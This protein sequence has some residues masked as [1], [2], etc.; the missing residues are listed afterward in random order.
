MSAVTQGHD[1]GRCSH[2]IILLGLLA[3]AQ[4]SKGVDNDTCS[5]AVHATTR[6]YDMPHHS[7]TALHTKDDVQEHSEQDN[8]EE[9]VVDEAKG[10]VAA[11]VILAS[12]KQ[13]GS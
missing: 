5:A 7:C 6:Q 8:V 1:V 9:V 12:S 10:P 11:V 13:V 4:V 3:G 2:Y